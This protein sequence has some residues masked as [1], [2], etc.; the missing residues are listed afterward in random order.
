MTEKVDKLIIDAREL[1]EKF[2]SSFESSTATANELIS[3]LGSTL[4]IEKAKLE[5]LHTSIQT[6]RAELNSFI[7][8][9]I[10][11]LQEDLATE[12]KI[13][14]ALAIKTEKV[15]VLTVKLENAEKRV[16]DLLS[17]KPVMKSCIADVKLYLPTSL[18][19]VT[20]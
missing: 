8:S 14:D 19:L 16:N 6:D 2:Q 20:R 10:T 9:K 7:S 13:M 3:I 4:K 17:E 12:S 5:Q 1:I 11:K 15:K 18:R